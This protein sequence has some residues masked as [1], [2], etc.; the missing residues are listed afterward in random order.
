MSRRSRI[1]KRER[2]KARHALRPKPVDK[3]ISRIKTN[4]LI[5]DLSRPLHSVALAEA[6]K[7]QI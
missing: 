7:G 5:A 2:Q 4:D 6:I 1:R 3:P